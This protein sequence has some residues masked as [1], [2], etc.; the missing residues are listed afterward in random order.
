ML[1]VA[2]HLALSQAAGEPIEPLSFPLQLGIV[3]FWAAVGYPLLRFVLPRVTRRYLGPG[4]A[5]IAHTPPWGPVELLALAGVLVF[6]L[7]FWSWLVVGLLP[8]SPLNAL[9]ATNL[10]LWTAALG[11]YGLVHVSAWQMRKLTQAPSDVSV[12]RAVGLGLGV[13]GGLSAG[14]ALQFGLIALCISV[15]AILAVMNAT[16]LVLELFGREQLSQ[17][18]LDNILS[19]RGASL[20]VGFVLASVV[21]PTLEEV[22]F[23]GFLQP[24][25][26]PRFGALPAIGLTSLA[27]ASLH[28]VDALIPIFF[29]SLLLGWLR[30]RT[31]RV[32]AA[33][34][35]HCLWNAGTLAVSVLIA[36]P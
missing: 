28:G 24:T 4:P 26:V 29:L 33:I 31:G 32:E 36:T 13:R 22:L 30:H 21:G 14:R 15:P 9:L 17:V 19:Q 7:Q 2:S 10:G 34:A 6:S 18:V 5:P 20:A 23:R 25:L 16:P 1:A 12:H 11:G 35:A 3:L 27:F 8:P